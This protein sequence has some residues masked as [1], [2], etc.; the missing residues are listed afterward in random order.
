MIERQ[1]YTK[2]RKH[3]TYLQEVMQLTPAS[4]DR[5]RFYL[6]HLLLWAEEKDFS[7]AAEIRPTLPAYLAGLPGKAGQGNLAGA[8]QKKI[9]DTGKRFFRWAKVTYPREFH[10]LPLTWIDT[11]RMVRQPQVTSENVFVSEEEV[12]Q[13]LAV[14]AE[15]D[16]LALIRDQAAAAFLF[17]SGMRGS[18]FVTLPVSAID[19]ENRTIRQWPELGVRTKNGKKATTFLL[20]IPDFLEAV[21]KWDAM[22]RG[23]TPAF[24]PWYAPIEHYWG[25]QSLSQEEP[26]QHRLQG[27]EKRLEL[28]FSLARLEYKSPHKFRHGHAVYGLLHARTMADY[29]AVSMNLMHESIE[30]TDSTY[31]PMVSSDVQLR[32]A[33]LSGGGVSTPDQ[34]KPQMETDLESYLSGLGKESLGKALVF[35]AGK[36]TQ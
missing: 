3:L 28:L 5:Y 16:N 10:G 9:L 7:Q 2:T 6:R 26:G 13:L 24:A 29:K 18:A 1:N 11:L 8:T 14:P 27:L 21:T 4:L 33:G 17:L 32:I 23:S 36:L 22:V 20:H 30:I 19:L 12:R 34:A 15:P 35:I 25:E 31:A